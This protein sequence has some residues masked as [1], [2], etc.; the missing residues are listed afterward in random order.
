MTTLGQIAEWVS[1]RLVGDPDTPISGAA[2]IDQAGPHQITFALEQSIADAALTA[3]RFPPAAFIIP[4]SVRINTV[5]TIEV[6]DPESAFAAV[7]ARFRPPVER[8]W[9]GIADGAY[10]SPTAIVDRTAT[11][12]PGAFVGDQSRI[13]AGT[14]VFPNATILERCVI[15]RDVRIFPNAVLYED[16]VV[17]DQS[18]IHAGAVVGAFGFGYRTRQGRHELSAQLGNTVI[19]CKVDLGANTTVDRGTYGSTVV[20]DGSKIDNLV[21]VAHNCRIGVHSVICSQVGIAGSCHIGDWVVMAGQVG[22][23]DHLT[24]GDHAVLAAKAGVMHDVPAGQTYVGAP[25]APIREQ[26]VRFAVQARL[27][28]MRRTISTLEKRVG[29]LEEQEANRSDTKIPKAA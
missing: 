2:P 28:E 3:S 18:I 9:H 29:R 26:M 24:V 12:Y 11:I 20:G 6:E 13:G 10:V 4:T 1:G 27:P 21:M 7:L 16:S 15:G 22:L 25:A 5:P 14:V 8:S 19:G 23:A 17:G